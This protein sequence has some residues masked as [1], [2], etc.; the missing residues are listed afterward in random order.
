MDAIN[1]YD[2]NWTN[3]VL[4]IQKWSEKKDAIDVAILELSAP[5]L[6]TRDTYHLVAFLKRLLADSNI[7]I[8]ICGI[9]MCRA[10]ASGLRKA[11]SH[12]AKVLAPLL[13]SKL[14]DKKNQITD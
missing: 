5:K 3:K 8:Q 12:G 14:R 1:K 6:V 7:A 13:I 2:E 11:F 10:L 9:K 4:E